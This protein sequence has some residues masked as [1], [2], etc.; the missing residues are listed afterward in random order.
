MKFEYRTESFEIGED[1]DYDEY[2]NMF[3]QNGWT[4][5]AMDEWD[6]HIFFIFMRK[7]EIGEKL[8]ASQLKEVP[9]N[10]DKNGSSEAA[11]GIQE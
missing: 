3:G 5:Q 4:L 1:P 11:G 10:D 7:I 8:R 6:G 2:L 9:N